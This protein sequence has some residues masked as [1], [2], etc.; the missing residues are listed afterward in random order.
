MLE[1]ELNGK[2]YTEEDLI[3]AAGGKDKL[4]AYIKSK[5]F[6]PAS[7]KTKQPAK[8]DER[9]GEDVYKKT[10]GFDNPAKDQFSEINKT[11]KK[12][13]VAKKWNE[14]VTWEDLKAEE[15][16]VAE[17]LQ[18]R[19]ARFGLTPEEKVFGV[20]RITLRGDKKQQLDQVVDPTGVGTGLYD[21]P[22]VVVGA[23]ASKEELI[24]S[25]KILN[26]YIGK[27]GNK[28]YI[29]KV[30][31]E[32]PN[33]VRDAEQK[34]QAPTRTQDTKVKEYNED[35]ANEFKNKETAKKNALGIKGGYEERKDIQLTKK[36]FKDPARY[37][38]YKSWKNSGQIA[39]PNEKELEKFIKEKNDNYRDNKSAELMSDA[40]QEQRTM[41]LAL[42]SEREDKA[43]EGKVKLSVESDEIDKASKALSEKITKFQKTPPTKQEY[44][45]IQKEYFALQN[46]SNAYNKEALALNRDF[47]NIKA[48]SE[49]ASKDYS[50]LNQTGTFLKQ[51][52]LALAGAA[53]DIRISTKAF[54]WALAQSVANGDSFGETYTRNKSILKETLLDPIYSE[55]KAASKELESYQRDLQIKDIKSMKDFGRWGAGILTQMP[56]SMAMAVTGEAALPLFFLSGYGSKQYEIA[57]LQESALSRL[58]YNA[59]Q[60]NKGLVAAEDMADVQKQIASDKKTL[61]ISE[62]AKLTSQVLAG[63]AEVLLEKYGTLGI[64]KQTDNILR[65]IPP[66]E[67]KRQ[68]KVIGKEMGKSA[69]VESWTEGLTQLANNFG[70]IH[71][72]GQ[73]KNYFDGVPDAMAGGAFMGPG[74]SAMGGAGTIS[75][76]I[77]KSVISELATKEEFK[78]RNKKLDEIKKLTGLDDI[79]GLTKRELNKLKLQPPIKKA[80]EDLIDQME[81]DDLRILDRLGK[82]FSMEDAKKVGDFNQK[83][84]KITRDWNEASKTVGIDDAQLRS[85]KEYYQ[86]Q[87]NE[88]FAAR[89]AMLTD[90][91]L[92]GKNKK[93]NA[94]K[95]ITFEATAGYNLYKRRL[96][97]KTY[98]E[99]LAGF[100]KLS[101][102][103]KQKYNDLALSELNQ[104]ATMDQL[105]N[106][107]VD[108]KARELYAGEE[109]GKQ[110]DRDIQAANDFSTEL[111]L[112]IKIE[113]INSE[114]ELLEK[115]GKFLDEEELKD[116]LNGKTNGFNI[117][118]N[119]LVVYKPNAIK[120]GHTSTGSHEVLHTVLSKAFQ[121][122]QEE[123]NKNGIKLLEYLKTA[124][125]SLYAAVEERMKAYK[126]EYKSYGEEVFNALSDSFSDGKIP[127]DDV[128]TQ[129]SKVVNKITKGAFGTSST[130]DIKNI[131]TDSG[132]ALFDTIKAY[133]QKAGAKKTKSGQNIRFINS[134][135]EDKAAEGTPTTGFKASKTKVDEVQK[136][137]DNL[138]DQLDKGEIDY[139]DY[140]SRLEIF[141]ADLAKAKLMPEE[142][143]KSTIKKEV[144]EEEADKEIIK[145]EKGSI[146]SDKVQRIYE[147]KG[148]NGAQEIIDLFKPI[149]KKL[150]NKRMDAPGFDR[151]LLT[152]EIETGDGGILYLIRSYKPET[153]VPLAAYINKQLPLRAIAASRR[154][155]DKDFSKDVTEEKGLIAEETV[156]ETKEKPKYK[157]ALESNIFS[158]EIL[159]TATNKIITIVR[160]LKNRIDAPVTL[161]RTVT[162]LISEIRDEVGKQLD[163]D[164]KTMLGGKKD[165]VFRKELLR[166][167]RY[168]LENMT[169]TWL[170]GKDGQGG[171]PQ[172]IQKQIDGKWVSYPDWVGKKIDREKTT[173]D[174]AGRTS[175]AELVRR[176][177]NAFNNVSDEAFLGQ[178]IGPDG[179]PIRG[180]KESVSKAMAE[181]G[182]FDIINAD[183]EEEGPIFE[184][185]TTNQQRLGYEIV[186][187]TAVD[188]ARQADRGNVKL[189]KTNVTA[190]DRIGTEFYDFYVKSNIATRALIFRYLDDRK[191]KAIDD[192][193]KDKLDDILLRWE[194]AYNE[195][196]EKILAK[197][198][199]KRKKQ[200]KEEYPNVEDFDKYFAFNKYF[201]KEKESLRVSKAVLVEGLT[202]DGLK[203][204][205]NNEDTLK[206]I[207]NYI[208]SNLKSQI[209]KSENENEKINVID[210]FLRTYRAVLTGGR[211]GKWFTEGNKDLF[212]KLSKE[213]EGFDKL[214][215]IKTVG[216]KS[217]IVKENTG[218]NVTF[219][220]E[221]SA[222]KGDIKEIIESGIDKLNANRKNQVETARKDAIAFVDSI[223]TS[224]MSPK[225]Q[226]MAI[227]LMNSSTF[228]P[229]R[230][231]AMVDSIILDKN[232]RNAEGYTWEHV[233]PV[234]ETIRNIIS[235]VLDLPFADKPITTRENLVT[236]FEESKISIL[237]NNINSILNTLLQNKM[238]STWRIGDNPY[239][240]RYFSKEVLD[241]LKANGIV[242]T[243]A[244]LITLKGNEKDIDEKLIIDFEARKNALNISNSQEA[245]IKS[246]KPSKSVEGIS[247]FDFDDTVGLTKGSV[248]Y[249]MPN[250]SK[251]KLNAE[252]FAKNGSKLL[253]DGAVFDF[254]EFSKVVDGKPGPMVEKMKKM[255]GK[256]GPENFFI[257]TARPADA[258]GPIHE[259]LSSIG[260]NIPLENI[261][262]LGNS[263][264][265]A[266]ADWMTAKAA[267]GYNDFYFADDAPQ[268]VEAVKKALD[269]PGITSKVQ[270]ARLKF[271][272][273]SR[274]D[275]NWRETGDSKFATFE[276]KG[277][278]Y[279]LFLTDTGYF[280]WGDRV[281]ATLN[282]LINKYDLDEPALLGSYEGETLNLVFSDENSSTD[283]TGRGNAAEV[284]GTVINGVIDY[285]NANNTDS[286]IFTAKEPSRIKLYDAIASTIANKLKWNVFSKNGIYIVS[287]YPAGRGILPFENQSKAVQDVLNVVDVKSPRQQAKIKFSKTM[288]DDF[289]RIIEE[290]KGVESYKVFSDITARRRG[291]KK[292]RFDLY[293]PPSAADFELLLY[294]FMG[295]GALGEEQK[296]FFQDA[297]M[298]PY[299]N[300]VDMMDAVRQSIKREYKALL[301][302]FPEIKKELEKLTPNKDFTYDQ[303]M[304]VAIWNQYGT[305]IPG[306]SQRDVTYLTDLINNDP[307]LA[308]FKDGLIVMGRQKDGWLPPGT[309]WDSDTIVSDL[310]NITEGSG[311]KKFLAEFIENTENIFGKWEGGRLVGPNMNKVEAVYGTNVR[312]ALEDSIYRM[313]NGKNRSFGQDKETTAWS[314]WVNGSTGAIMF[315]NTRSAA[316]QMLGAVNF[317]NWRDNNPFN[318]GKAFLNQPQ[319]WKDFAHI[320]NSDKLKE[321]RGGLRE[322][323][324]S[325]E[326]ANAAAGSKNK[327][328]AVTSYLLKI[329]YTPTQLA[330]SF[331]IASG[332]APFYRN[333]INSYLK[334]GLT[335]QEAE[336]KAWQD[337]SKV[338]DET[339]QSGDPK[340]ISKQQS[341]GA[342]RLLLVFQNFTMQQSRIVKKAVLDLKNGRGDA[343]TNIAKIAYY[344]A[345]QNIMFST[346][347]Q[348]LFA[349][350]FDDDEED[351]D[352]KKKKRTDAAF[353]VANGV[354]DSILRGTGFVGGITATLK[355]TV[356]KYLEERAKKQKAEYAKVVLEAANMSPP[357]GSKLRK[358]YSALQ[359]TKYDKDLIEAR[360]WGVMQ[361]GRV[362]LG[363]MY[364]VT[365]K[366]VEVGTNFPMDRLVNKIENVSQAFNSENTAMQRLAT[367]MG[368]SPWT[369]GIEGTK[370]DI[371]IKETAKAKRKEEGLIK[372]KETRKENA[373]KLKDSIKALSI[374]ERRAYRLKVA[375]E[376]RE[377]RKEKALEKKEERRKKLE[378]FKKLN[379]N[380]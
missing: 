334:E 158:S 183:F 117:D 59:D 313:I 347:Q 237:P 212:G 277:K 244:D 106:K 3:K 87:Y 268:N 269:V 49:A 24:A 309:F 298:I 1:Y 266:K 46:R 356:V 48:V 36:D 130:Y 100:D 50:R 265:Q 378:M 306:L 357:I 43:I 119:T 345:V 181:E 251:G 10:F 360:G 285:A 233:I 337:F 72:L 220:E 264:A 196:K 222:R 203:F 239:D 295:K 105:S 152:D 235:Y 218:E 176:L 248:L 247:V 359:Q 57:S 260:I 370:G 35:L 163:I 159:K 154:V 311:R 42:E 134:D 167:K 4:P 142:A 108:S 290:N 102:E 160:T 174:Q 288:S 9:F 328:V 206:E 321:R 40:P 351:E 67:I 173:T 184:A 225:A 333:R 74:F 82:D 214:Y 301:K 352:K 339:Q 354:L 188:F 361:D 246:L 202:K 302:S 344:L 224:G 240:A 131:S 61:N 136:K 171:I 133:S 238:A 140:E 286:F 358:T 88:V 205:K 207:K 283:I 375:L 267:E 314:S 18:K 353:D 125:P 327:V 60:I 307:E 13:P 289:N 368:Y 118:D 132:K 369:V 75:N 148:V 64:I 103:E 241:I 104:D 319:Y 272:L 7:K 47:N 189:A 379:A 348:G 17:N 372:A 110:L 177:P 85:L 187:H 297:L 197:I 97:R 200:Q 258:A 26:D 114:K 29:Q 294:N 213:I 62:G 242:L 192:D 204:V 149:T 322:D 20:N 284:F 76:N 257:L 271:S 44:D 275:L 101:S 166:T 129:I 198:N 77:T 73:D 90:K 121:G 332:G 107:E 86:K 55:Q 96:T 19:V 122:N 366:L 374:P 279:S 56:S 2:I 229:L 193:T 68:L 34:I 146:S 252:E 109:I 216:D 199:A 209:E 135:T 116:F 373:Q 15:T 253:E 296:K 98:L 262:G 211:Q 280:N 217:T 245:T 92:T 33:L 185:F 65:A 145:N 21:L 254:S 5:G 341:S 84:R 221:Q 139:E 263:T 95:R 22:E 175:G 124:Q 293:V 150:V 115:Y 324:A 230:T 94:Q 316:L 156:S 270:Q 89:E 127:N 299:I 342:G 318:A 30:K 364:S 305:E 161:N 330:D 250:G 304:R 32:N 312:E 346:L 123:A 228:S 71:L 371:L 191:F 323:V 215:A 128:F 93:E 194:N 349:V 226:V 325:A 14:V 274:Q 362:H 287:K 340:D 276:V 157:N 317:L 179:N 112:N 256:F 153:G 23:D 6:K 25:A 180:R 315:L 155:L 303:A 113:T 380:E 99:K 201:E 255:I 343:K 45:E 169:T 137:I 236:L 259:F 162:P 219:V 172:A 41:L 292:N 168:I 367:G 186:A 363:P 377:K 81:G 261:T 278:E 329:G 53:E 170:M 51:T 126:P 291:L 164:L 331:A 208:Y 365:G 78:A 210:S 281:E 11:K 91:Q 70:D 80:V 310:Y 243:S 190:V 335:E 111:G 223:K 231:M 8:L 234:D 37:D 12:K 16:T 338:S 54:E 58:Q 350:M 31:K 69:G 326:I 151:E 147:E 120:N 249:T 66:Q 300:G 79:T 273:N 376:K 39:L 28:D 144:T 63:A 52:G 38:V 195:N 141:E 83:L 182:A 178:F 336:S 308:A 320:W 227:L 27:Y 143:P 232:N 355:N 138:E 165:G 282:T